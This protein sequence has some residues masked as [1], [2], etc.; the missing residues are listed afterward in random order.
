M[1]LITGNIF[2]HDGLLLLSEGQ[3]EH[4]IYDMKD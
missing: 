4:T 1:F 3:H 2:A